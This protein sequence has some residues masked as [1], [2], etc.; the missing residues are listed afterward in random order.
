MIHKVLSHLVDTMADSQV[1]NAVT[2]EI[3][4]PAD[5]VYV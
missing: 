5:V 2:W 3:I 1:V 4:D